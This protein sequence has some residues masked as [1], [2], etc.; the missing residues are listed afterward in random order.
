MK[1]FFDA[2]GYE[3]MVVMEPLFCPVYDKDGNDPCPSSRF[4]CDILIVD[5]GPRM[6]G[7]RLLTAQF[8]HGCKLTSRNKA[9]ISGMLT[10][11]QRDAVKAM[12]MAIFCNPLDFRELE[13]WVHDCQKRMDLTKPL[14]GKRTAPRQTCN[15]EVRYRALNDDAGYHARALN[16]SRCGICIKTP[17]RLKHRQVIHLWSA[18]PCISEDAEVRWMQKSGDGMYLA[19]LTFCVA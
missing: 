18:E 8:S 9:M 12:G 6:D 16:I 15:I 7:V 17:H 1:L 10:D 5:D 2:K 19:G 3:T 4:C 11:D 13:S 14:A